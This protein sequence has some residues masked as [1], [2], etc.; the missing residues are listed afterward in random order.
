MSD[1]KRRLPSIVG[2]SSLLVIFAVVCL[3]VFSILTISTAKAQ[4]HFATVN[5]ESVSAFYKADSKAEEIFATI[6]SGTIPSGVKSNK[7]VYSYSC[8]ISDTLFLQ[9]E[10]T[11]ENGKWTVLRWEAVSTNV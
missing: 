7:G 1:K 8:K 10:V 5:A 3:S 11:F 6:R 4:E 9:V 2:G